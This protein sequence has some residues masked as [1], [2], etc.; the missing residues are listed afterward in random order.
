[1]GNLA[2]LPIPECNANPV[3]FFGSTPGR[4]GEYIRNTELPDGVSRNTDG[5]NSPTNNCN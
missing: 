3:C 1:M 5:G 4:L 2:G